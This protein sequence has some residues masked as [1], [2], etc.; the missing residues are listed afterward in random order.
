VWACSQRC[1]SAHVFVLFLKYNRCMRV[2]GLAFGLVACVLASVEHAAAQAEPAKRRPI[3]LVMESAGGVHAASDLRTTLNRDAGYRVL[4]L[5]E[6]QHEAV[7]P[8]AV[9]TVAT[10]RARVVRVVYWDLAG[11]TDSLTAA[12]PAR[13]EDMPAVVLALSSALLERHRSDLRREP[14]ESDARASWL[15]AANASRAFYAVLGRISRLSPRTNVELRFED[16]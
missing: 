13:P 15:D 12:T 10:D 6:A 11:D 5:S 14:R 2:I 3:V 7:R 1:V 4:S 8:S 16:F 9:L